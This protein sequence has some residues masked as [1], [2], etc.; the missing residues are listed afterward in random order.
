MQG[1]RKKSRVLTLDLEGVETC[2]S[3]TDLL[4]LVVGDQQLNCSTRAT[5][6]ACDASVTPS[7]KVVEV[8][9]RKTRQAAH[10]DLVGGQTRGGADGV[11]GRQF[12]VK[13][14]HIPVVMPLADHHQEHLR[15][16]VVD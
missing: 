10:V 2:C 14:A 15:H 16:R 11:V 1:I 7:G 9:Y 5:V 6:V 13:K 4:K 8:D 3:R 12:H